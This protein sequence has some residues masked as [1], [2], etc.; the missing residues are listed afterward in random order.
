MSIKHSAR[1]G[2]TYYLHVTTGSKGQA[3]YFFS[4]KSDASL[5]QAIPDGYEIYENVNAQV[6]LRKKT[7]PLIRDGEISLIQSALKK[8]AEEWKYKAEIKKDMIV[9]HEACQEYDWLQL[10]APW[11]DKSKLEQI[12]IQNTHY[13]PI[14][15]FIL[16]DKGRRIFRAERYCVRGSIDDW[17]FIGVPNK[18]N[19]LAGKFIKHLGQESF[20]ELL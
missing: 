14:M 6:F 13:L 7:T 5:A 12:K 16:E 17:I 19:V 11:G 18:L 3:K 1:S 15:R 10:L 8:H 20:Y 2:K 4:T 9:I